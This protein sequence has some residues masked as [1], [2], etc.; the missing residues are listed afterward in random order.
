MSIEEKITACANSVE[1]EAIQ[2]GPM[3]ML[4]KPAEIG[5]VRR[6]LKI[7]TGYLFSRSRN[8][9]PKEI[10]DVVND[11]KQTPYKK[12]YDF[13]IDN[14]HKIGSHEFRFLDSFGEKYDKWDEMIHK[15]YKI[16][17]NSLIIFSAITA[18]TAFFGEAVP[19]AGKYLD[20]H[21]ILPAIKFIH[22]HEGISLIGY[23]L[24][25]RGK[26]T[27]RLTSNVSADLE[28]DNT[29]YNTNEINLPREFVPEVN[30][31]LF[32]TRVHCKGTKCEERTEQEAK[33]DERFI[34]GRYSPSDRDIFFKFFSYNTLNSDGSWH[35]GGV[36]TCV[37]LLAYRAP[38]KG[39]IRIALNLNVAVK[40]ILPAPI[41]Y[42]TG[43]QTVYSKENALVYKPKDASV[44]LNS[45]LTEPGDY[46]TTYIQAFSDRTG[47]VE[48]GVTPFYMLDSRLEKIMGEKWKK[49][50][51]STSWSEVRHFFEV[52][53]KIKYPKAVEKGLKKI[54]QDVNKGRVK[55]YDELAQRVTHVLENYFVYNTSPEN[56]RRFYG[57]DNFVNGALDLQGVDCDTA[58]APLCAVLRA[59]YDIPTRLDIGIQGRDGV[60]DKRNFHSVCEAYIP[61]RGWT[62]YDATPSKISS[63]AK[64]TIKN[65]KVVSD[66]SSAQEYQQRRK[67]NINVIYND[68]GAEKR[69]RKELAERQGNETDRRGEESN[70]RI[71]RERGD[72]S[73]GRETNV[74]NG[75][76]DTTKENITKETDT[77]NKETDVDI[78]RTIA[79]SLLGVGGIGLIMYGVHWYRRRREKKKLW[80]EPIVDVY[81]KEDGNVKEGKISLN[82]G[83]EY[84]V[85]E[86]LHYYQKV[87]DVGIAELMQGYAAQRNTSKH[88][89]DEQSQNPEAKEYSKDSQKEN[90]EEK[91]QKESP[92]DYPDGFYVLDYGFYTTIL[93]ALIKKGKLIEPPKKAEDDDEI[94][95]EEAEGY[96]KKTGSEQ[97]ND[98]VAEGEIAGSKDVKNGVA[99]NEI[100]TQAQKK[101]RR[102]RPR[103]SGLSLDLSGDGEISGILADISLSEKALGTKQPNEVIGRYHEQIETILDI[104]GGICKA[105]NYSA[106]SVSGEYEFN[107]KRKT[108]AIE[109]SQGSL[110]QFA[111]RRFTR[112]TI[113]VNLNSQKLQQPAAQLRTDGQFIDNLIYT[114]MLAN[115]ISLSRFNELK[116][117]YL[118]RAYLNKTDLHI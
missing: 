54:D 20:N 12:F 6:V 48:F 58:N 2:Q 14:F 99:K 114:V 101:Q 109:R 117:T 25:E 38:N 29:E 83:I 23:R 50:R 39:N 89:S 118:N 79:Y 13:L 62:E 11:K 90:P 95:N 55:T 81:I 112:P 76:N 1:G 73:K 30:K 37:N 86:K 53:F 59:R 18:T 24:D 66:G 70:G 31:K 40:T 47:K 72:E 36:K 26:E 67:N 65:G 93:D 104:V 94:D 84:I 44:G 77:D 17:R 8:Q 60:L 100:G 64:I 91:G 68:A 42:F 51:E 15:A 105:N 75:T 71:E 78:G 57:V 80:E 74:D 34:I 41:G 92:K 35:N 49:R 16:A 4:T 5:F 110:R 19:L 82:K 106:I 98:E 3:T 88:I 85:E 22:E 113:Y 111:S 10:D 61:N 43:S 63:E 28:N 96:I 69:R 87:V 45:C 46:D 52:P 27:G 102:R 32:V 97:V 103:F 21:V 33:P 7:P 116:K 107:N 56:A 9:L 108:L 115:E